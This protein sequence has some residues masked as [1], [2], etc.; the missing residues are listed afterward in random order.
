[1]SSAKITLLSFYEWMKWEDSDLFLQL[2]LPEGI[3]KDTL[4]EN[5]LMRGGEFEVIYSDPHF[6]Q[7]AIGSWSKKW[8]RTFTKWID[9]LNIEYNP[10]ENYDRME[11]YSDTYNKGIKT[12]ARRDSGNTRT[13]DN[14]D[15]LTR[16]S[17]DE[18]THDTTDV[19]EREVSAY[20]SSTYQP[21]EKTTTDLDGTDTTTYTGTDTT[22]HSGT[23]KDE[24]GEGSSGS[25][26][27][28]SK[29]VHSGRLHG[30]IGVTTSQQMLEAELDI[31]RWNIYEHITDIFLSEFIIPIYS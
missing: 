29:N 7:K 21:A 1:M 6:L 2:S 23:I 24:Y 17:Q 4:T 10:L 9:A 22:T 30:N 3:D 26:T 27:E 18:L 31:A 5:I 13:F 25:E 15:E 19:T 11:D 28:N 16:D 20:D 8:Y 12:Q 14:Q